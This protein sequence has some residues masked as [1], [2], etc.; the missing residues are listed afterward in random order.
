MKIEIWSDFVC[1]FCY[2]GNKRLEDALA[3]FDHAEDV[4][5]EYKSYQLD[6]TAKHIPGKTMN[7]TLAELKGMPLPQV[8]QMNKQVAEMADT[9]GL[10]FNNDTAQYANTFDAHR[11]FHYAKEVGKGN[12]YDERLKK[13]YFTD[14]L[15]ISDFNTLVD[16]AA[17]IGLDREEARVVLESERYAS[18]VRA[19]I[20]EAKQ[21]G[22]QG[23]PFFVFDRKYAVSGA[24]PEEV[25]AKTLATVW[26]DK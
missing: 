22:V 6:P 20:N 11:L 3:K 14:S 1:P 10:T 19:E 25:F 18:N 8:E 16:L 9:V 21:I 26:S 2:I 23:V 13:A 7:E 24:Q 17:E 12:E 5:I 15:L 4:E